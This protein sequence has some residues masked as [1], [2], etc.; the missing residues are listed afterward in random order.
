MNS[1]KIITP[2]PRRI[3]P[4]KAIVL[5]WNKTSNAVLQGNWWEDDDAISKSASSV[6]AKDSTYQARRSKRDVENRD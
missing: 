6:E 5:G 3:I 4:L 1:D 2:R